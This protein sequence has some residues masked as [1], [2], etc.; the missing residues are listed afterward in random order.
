MEPQSKH[1]L[2]RESASAPDRLGNALLFGGSQ[3]PLS[4]LYWLEFP[5]IYNGVQYHSSEQAY[6]HEKLRFLGRWAQA[7]KIMDHDDPRQAKLRGSRVFASEQAAW[8][9]GPA[10]AIMKKIVA[11]KIA[12]NSALAE[13]LAS[14]VDRQ[15]IEATRNETW[16]SGLERGRLIRLVQR[17]PPFQEIRL[18]GKA[19]NWMGKIL[20]EL[21]E[22]VVE[23]RIDQ[24]M[25]A[26]IETTDS[27]VV[28]PV[29][30][31]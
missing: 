6:Q 25:L 24:E 22:A 9:E 16:G 30:R 29:D 12:Q 1:E 17:S 26:D 5:L 27:P 3:N 13:Y 23:G 15:F 10:Y 20:N 7:A 14:K 31:K 4:N 8:I 21:A 28:A 11:G 2:A 18:P 19:K